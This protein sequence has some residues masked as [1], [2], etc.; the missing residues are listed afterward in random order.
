MTRASR[1]GVL[2]ASLASLASLAAAPR[3]HA[4]TACAGGRVVTAEGYCCW[5]G[6]RWDAEDLRCS[7]AP[8]CP[9]PLTAAGEACVDG[10]SPTREPPPRAPTMVR[11]DGTVDYGAGTVTRPRQAIAAPR[12]PEPAATGPVGGAWPLAGRA[13][14][15][16]PRNPRR[17][18]R[19][20]EGLQVTG[21]LFFGFAYASAVI[22]SVAA[23][24]HPGSPRVL[25][26]MG[27]RDATCHDTIGAF[28][29][30]PVIGAVV[31]AVVGAECSIPL[32]TAAG[33][34]GLR[35]GQTL[36][37]GGESG[38]TT[39]AA[40]SASFQILG[41]GM[42]LLG[43]SLSDEVTVYDDGTTRATLAPLVGAAN[44]LR[45]TLEL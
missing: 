31:A 8:S 40:L 19:S 7:G 35:T 17:V 13:P 37:I 45:L 15:W 29:L 11:A 23:F 3:A 9:A 30:V 12:E 33:G 34:A 41:L 24:A 39:S 26:G 42:F 4:Q 14:P 2:L 27:P 36:S 5:P 38:W 22:A 25:G 6:Q 20:I 43:T 32:Y 21:A 18:T 44:G 1:A 16:G 28:L 10:T